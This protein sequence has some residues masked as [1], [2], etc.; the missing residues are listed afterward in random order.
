MKQTS[1]LKLGKIT[2][3]NLTSHP[4]T[5]YSKHHTYKIEESLNSPIATYSQEDL[6]SIKDISITRKKVDR[7]VNMPK[8]KDNTYYI[9]SVVIASALPNRKD[10][11]VPD[12]I[13]KGRQVFGCVGFFQ[14]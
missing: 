4:I 10:L 5:I 12:S 1:R 3:V 7:V 11:L 2:L 14:L 6:P 8:E 9:V 13:K